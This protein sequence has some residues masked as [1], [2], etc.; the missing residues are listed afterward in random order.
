[1]GFGFRK[2][3]SKVI[4]HAEENKV[5]YLT[6]AGIAFGAGAIYCA[7]KAGPKYKEVQENIK[8]HEELRGEPLK[9]TEKAKQIVGV[10]GPTAMC[11]AVSFAAQLGVCKENKELNDRLKT[12]ETA[13]EGLATA[14]KIRQTAIDSL[15]PE[16]RE[17]L[18]QATKGV[19]NTPSQARGKTIPQ[20]SGFGD[21]VIKDFV[22]GQILYGSR[23]HC[24]SVLADI[25]TELN[26]DK[27][28]DNQIDWDEVL[29]RMG[30]RYNTL[31]GKMLIIDRK[32]LSNVYITYDRHDGGDK[33]WYEMRVHGLTLSPN[34][35]ID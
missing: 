13:Y 9:A 23:G 26:E 6:A 14:A 29:Q 22:T 15:P 11:A 8:K 24:E 17:Q 4:K 33:E 30:Y 10:F 7:F 16:Q 12:V 18:E 20:K 3:F 25:K 34:Y 32:N 27:V 1:M 5:N 28:Y 35:Y 21:E 19:M 2:L 31:V